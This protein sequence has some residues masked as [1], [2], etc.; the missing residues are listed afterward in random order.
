MEILV[1]YGAYRFTYLA[2]KIVM[3]QIDD[4]DMGKHNFL[5][6]LAFP[7]KITKGILKTIHRPIN[8]LSCN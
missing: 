4:L 3:C 2:V 7:G 1:F 8:A 6:S 5:I